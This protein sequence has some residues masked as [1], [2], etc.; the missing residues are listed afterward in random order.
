MD[1]AGSHSEATRLL[2]ARDMVEPIRTKREHIMCPN[3]LP[4][5][6]QIGGPVRLLLVRKRNRIRSC[7]GHMSPGAGRGLNAHTLTD[8]TIDARCRAGAASCACRLR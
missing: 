2:S 3:P 4:D 5:A 6:S 1:Q 7:E 8:E